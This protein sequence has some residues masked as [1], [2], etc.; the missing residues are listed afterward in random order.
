MKLPLQEGFTPEPEVCEA[1]PEP[2]VCEAS[3][4]SCYTAL[5]FS[6]TG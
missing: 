4:D 1:S 6:K 3:P 5:A 2:E